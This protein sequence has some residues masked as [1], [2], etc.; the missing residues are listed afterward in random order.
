M[1]TPHPNEYMEGQPEGEVILCAP[2]P[3]PLA[4]NQ[5]LP[6]ANAVLVFMSAQLV[7]TLLLG[8]QQIFYG[9]A[10]I[11]HMLLTLLVLAA[12]LGMLV[13]KIIYELRAWGALP[14][15]E[16]NMQPILAVVL[17]FIP[18][19]SLYWQFRAIRGLSV[20]TDE[21]LARRGLPEIAPVNLGTFYCIYMLA[22]LFLNL[23]G[24]AYL[25]FSIFSRINFKSSGPPPD[26]S[27]LPEIQNYMLCLSII[28]APL[29][30]ILGL[31]IEQQCRAI[32]SLYGF[33]DNPTALC[34]RILF[35]FACV[36]LF[37]FSLLFMML[38][39]SSTL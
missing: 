23:I 11:I 36:A 7:V 21:S 32:H 28:S 39:H 9:H 38:L 4:P 33:K 37:F 30:L 6:I 1:S 10:F 19:F 22:F 29:Q 18:L 17:M 5:K 31:W 8:Y 26:F 14:E 27:N 25:M 15:N 20:R 16:R 13:F 24:V 12:G 3:I 2:G 34:P 35:L